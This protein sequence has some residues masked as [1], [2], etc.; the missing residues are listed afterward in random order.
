MLWNV[1]KNIFQNM[2]VSDIA[3]SIDPHIT[4]PKSSFLVAEKLRLIAR[5]CTTYNEYAVFKQTVELC[6]GIPIRDIIRDH[7][8]FDESTQEYRFIK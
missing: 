8:E 5:Q 2:D 3:K 7:I 4:V 1:Q 6:V